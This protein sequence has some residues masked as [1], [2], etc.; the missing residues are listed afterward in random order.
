MNKALATLLISTA[1]V[2]VH[3]QPKPNECATPAAETAHL[4]LKANGSE[5]KG[6][7]GGVTHED[8]WDTQAR[9]TARE[10]GSA[11]ATGKRLTN[12][13]PTAAAAPSDQA[14]SGTPTAIINTSRSNIKHRVSAAAAAKQDQSH[15]VHEL[16]KVSRAGSGG[17]AGNSED[18]PGYAVSGVVKNQHGIR[19]ESHQRCIAI[20][21]KGEAK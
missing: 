2:A 8:S 15:D 14:G 10:A 18:A 20:N 12:S 7:T 17:A 13:G 21:E 3:A 11:L 19:A 5:K 6:S 4:Y 1:S 16:E 9:K